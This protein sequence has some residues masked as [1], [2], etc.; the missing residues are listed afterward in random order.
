MGCYIIE[1]TRMNQ[2]AQRYDQ[3]QTIN[4]LALLRPAKNILTTWGQDS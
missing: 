1:L 4:S 3:D 2:S